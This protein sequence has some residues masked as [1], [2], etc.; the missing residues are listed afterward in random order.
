MIWGESLRVQPFGYRLSTYFSPIYYSC[1]LEI[2]Q[3][4]IDNDPEMLLSNQPNRYLYVEMNSF[5]GSSSVLFTIPVFIE[6]K[7]FRYSNTYSTLQNSSSSSFTS[8]FNDT[9]MNFS[10]LSNTLAE[11]GLQNLVEIVKDARLLVFDYWCLNFR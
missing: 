11:D 3:E 8:L 5:E 4:I 6:S 2:P 10:M 7:R 9:I 1:E